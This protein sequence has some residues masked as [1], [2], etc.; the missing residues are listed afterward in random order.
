MIRRDQ[1]KLRTGRMISLLVLF[2]GLTIL[3]PAAMV[4]ADD[5]DEL[6]REK[7]TGQP[8]TLDEDLQ[9][10]ERLLEEFRQL[11][12]AR[13]LENIAQ[14][15]SERFK[16][17]MA[18]ADERMRWVARGFRTDEAK[19]MGQLKNLGFD[20]K[21]I[22]TLIRNPAKVQAAIQVLQ[23]ILMLTGEDQMRTQPHGAGSVQLRMPKFSFSPE[24]QARLKDFFNGAD[25]AETEKNEAN[26]E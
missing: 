12:Q 23:N 24:E 10:V 16:R 22:E 11:L 19:A 8:L 1:T 26:K 4:R 6:G 3:P 7:A 17:A 25:Q 14:L 15:R 18:D 13:R 20:D 5:D 2:G 21:L 9:K